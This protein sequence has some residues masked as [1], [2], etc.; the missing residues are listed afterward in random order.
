MASSGNGGKGPNTSV[1]YSSAE[2]M[3]IFYFILFK[4]ILCITYNMYVL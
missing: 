1:A 2:H 3:G 4:M